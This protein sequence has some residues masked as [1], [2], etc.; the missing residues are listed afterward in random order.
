MNNYGERCDRPKKFASAEGR[1]DDETRRPQEV[2]PYHWW[3][4]MNS[5]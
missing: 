3:K 2:S 1:D 4:M 5:A